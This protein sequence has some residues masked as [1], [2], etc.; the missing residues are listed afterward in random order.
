MPLELPR[1]IVGQHRGDVHL[2]GP[3]QQSRRARALHRG[4]PRPGAFGHRR[5]ERDRHLHAVGQVAVVRRQAD[6]VLR[7]QPQRQPV[8]EVDRA[9]LVPRR[10]RRRA[11]LGQGVLR[12]G[13]F[14][15]L[16]RRQ[17]HQLDAEA[18]IELAQLLLEE[19][20][21][22]RDCR[23]WAGWCRW[24]CGR[25]SRR[26]DRARS[27]ACGRRRSPARTAGRGRRAGGWSRRRCPRAG[28]SARR[29]K[30]ACG[31]RAAGRR[32]SIGSSTG[33]APGRGG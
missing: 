1:R 19:L 22:L 17:D 12:A 7:A 25:P 10:F 3:L 31:R 6:D 14:L 16:G 27:R 15:D 20:H 24:R 28:R 8:G 18:G 29:R 33:P 2:F 11:C 9:V 5:G 32:G 4:E 30:G 23:G 13:P 26:R 21:Q